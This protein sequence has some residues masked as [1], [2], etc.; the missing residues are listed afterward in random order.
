MSAF[1]GVTRWM[2]G[3]M[4]MFGSLSLTAC[5]GGG[6]SAGD[7][8][9]GG[10]TNGGTAVAA[11]LALTV[12]KT[13]VPNTGAEQATITVTALD[14]SRNVV[15]DVP[16]AITVDNNAFVTP[17]GVKTDAATGQVTAKVA[18][19]S[20]TTNRTVT[21][22]AKS[23]SIT[24]TATFNVVDSVSGS[25]VSE[26]VLTLDK[27][28]LTNSGTDAVNVT[29]TALD[30]ARK[31]LGGVPVSFS[32]NANAVVTPEGG[33]TVTDTTTGQIKAALTIGADTSKRLITVTA[34]SGSVTRSLA[35]DVVDAVNVIPKAADLTLV[36]STT[37]ISDSGTEVVNV[38]ATA[39]D[40]SRNALAG[41]PVSFTVDQNAVLIA[42]G[43]A[44]NASGQVTAN[45]QIG[46]DRSN[47]IITVTATSDSLV[48]TASFQVTGAKLDGS[49]LPAI[50]AA[51][52][53]G[54]VQYRLKDVN[55]NALVGVPIS[56]SGA[57]ITSGAG[58]T[59]S[60]GA[61]TFNYLAPANAG[62][63]DI[64][65][66]AAG[67][68][69]VQSVLV[70]TGSSTV[71]AASIPVVS[72]ALSVDP[73]VVKINTELTSNRT[74]VRALFLGANNVPVKNVRV[75]FKI[76]PTNAV[77]GTLTVGNNMSYS[78][79]NGM[80]TTAYVPGTRSSPTDGLRLRACYDLNDFADFADTDLCPGTSKEIS[81]KL[82]VVSEALS[83]SIGTNETIEIGASNLTY[84][85][86]FVLLV[87]D[88]AGNAKPDVQI[89]PS[90]DLLAY[91][92]GFYTWNAAQSAWL[93][94]VTAHCINEDTNRNGSIDGS[95][96]T[97]H[98][99]ALDP[100]KS[101]AA[102][103]MVGTSKTDASGS[104]VLKIEYPKSHASWVH[105]KVSAAA[106]G[107]L[108]PPAV[109]S[110]VLPASATAIKT[111]T[112]PPAFV[113]SPYGRSSSCADA[114]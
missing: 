46:S 5:G 42:G 93:Q 48:R 74:E 35:F 17:S 105:F 39:V 40:A 84:I 45:V 97:N 114:N 55:N 44:T 78:D 12:D 79:A 37:N 91:D 61:Y 30:T 13:T 52:A 82:T 58:L 29:V 110:G 26:L 4:I 23:G 87:V 111:E 8:V 112:P 31:A 70:Q 72:A 15:G 59:D 69:N 3:A 102:I 67:V 27:T 56:V 1:S 47:R 9:L 20:D 6:G 19:G 94:T 34:T 2:A 38:T 103:S 96:D 83:V 53:A 28:K 109:S 54:Q 99:G 104:A 49:A 25:Q 43:T 80:A 86:K 90:I 22:T 21:L 77:G 7:P 50:L 81:V 57:G 33:K 108:S 100:R 32:I 88:S 71:P 107:V 73:N 76:D 36:L 24:K 60:N 113:V 62:S 66:L 51:G 106:F 101:D 14:A 98:N 68:T 64:T 95:E 10:G 89:T 16:I 65:A 75:R 92:K 63:I 18:I 85:Q 11:D 41:I